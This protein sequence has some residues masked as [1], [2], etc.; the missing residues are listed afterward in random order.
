MIDLVRLTPRCRRFRRR[1]VDTHRAPGDLAL[2]LVLVSGVTMILVGFSRA[3]A[4]GGWIPI[5]IPVVG[6]CLFERRYLRPGALRGK[7][8]SS[9]TTMLVKPGKPFLAPEHRCAEPVR[10]LYAHAVEA[11]QLGQLAVDDGAGGAHSRCED[12]R[13]RFP[14]GA[15]S[16]EQ[17]VML[18]SPYL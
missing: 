9:F 4:V 7:P 2:S 17:V 13:A 14:E 18:S 12:C 1:D 6:P 8:I 11:Y 3:S 5:P 10:R 15:I 16:L